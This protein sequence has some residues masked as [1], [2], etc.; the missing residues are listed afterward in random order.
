MASPLINLEAVQP[1]A[2]LHLLEQACFANPRLS[3]DEQDMGLAR[4]YA[5]E[6]LGAPVQ[7]LSAANEGQPCLHHPAQMPA[8]FL[9]RR[10]RPTGRGQTRGCRGHGRQ[11]GR[12]PRRQWLSTGDTKCHRV[13]RFLA[14]IRAT[15]L[16]AYPT[17]RTKGGVLAI[18]LRIAP[19]R[20]DPWPP[21]WPGACCVAPS[22][23]RGGRR[24]D[25][26]LGR[27]CSGTCGRRA[28]GRSCLRGSRG[29]RFHHGDETIAIAALGFDDPLGLPVIS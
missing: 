6:N 12:K 4:S 1:R 5:P 15:L 25:L 22:G 17:R 8:A 16:E 24:L 9:L 14:T 29:E 18:G 19:T 3:W 28:R 10:P 20:L 7:C 27:A 11:G 26:R 13:R 2:R 23:W 21:R